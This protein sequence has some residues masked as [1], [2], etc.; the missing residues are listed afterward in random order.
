MKLL[1]NLTIWKHS[2]KQI[3]NTF[4]TLEGVVFGNNIQGPQCLC[5]EVS[6]ASYNWYELWIGCIDG[7][8]E[9]GPACRDSELSPAATVPSSVGHSAPVTTTAA[10]SLVTVTKE[11][12]EDL[13]LAA[14]SSWCL[15]PFM[16]LVSVLSPIRVKSIAF[17]HSLQTALFLCFPSGAIHVLYHLS[18]FYSVPHEESRKLVFG[19]L[20]NFL[21]NQM[22]YEHMHVPTWS[23]ILCHL[24]TPYGF[25]SGDRHVIINGGINSHSAHHVRLRIFTTAGS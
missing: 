15:A 25:S 4:T 12:S 1:C 24:I 22:S 18:V 2:T 9:E 3:T 17:W 11:S 14:N 5:L 13:V 7:A 23:P 19:H 10:D 21:Q 16:W 8:Q 6:I 20:V